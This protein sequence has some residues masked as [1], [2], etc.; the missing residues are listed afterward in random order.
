M[1]ARTSSQSLPIAGA[2]FALTLAAVAF[3]DSAPARAQFFFNLP[4]IGGFGGG[5][6]YYAPRRS[7]GGYHSGGSHYA[8]PAAP[9][10]NAPPPT[11]QDS[12]R[13][14]AAL[15]PSTQAQLEVLKSISYSQIL[16]EV[17][18]PEDEADVG[19]SASGEAARDYTSKIEDLI[20]RI[21][22]IQKREGS[23]KD[24]DIS[25]HGILESM[26]AAYKAA[27]LQRFETFLGENW[28]AERLREMIIERAS[29]DIA[30]LFDG[31]NRGAVSMGDLDKLIRKS[32][33]S[34]YA[35]LFETSELLA[36]N[37][38][39]SMF[40]QRL[41]Q[42]HGDLMNG[43]VRED[44]EQMLLRASNA[45]VSTFDPLLRR[46]PNGFAL[47]YRAQRI[48]FDCLSA[49][50]EAISQAE[51][52]ES[53]SP[54]EI[55]QRILDTDEKQ[56]SKWVSV[57]LMGDD[58]KVKTQDPMPLRVIWSATG[59]KEDASMYTRASDL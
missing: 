23:T 28:S 18:A 53:A 32:A 17:G 39:S 35:R 43:D 45:G 15:A 26:T 21:K 4:G 8:Q 2:I 3:G 52:N 30:G 57:Q 19:K 41:Y 27:N 38:S 5:P 34:V 22:T 59:P 6:H 56:C 7:Y 51:N 16:G 49:N 46:D 50:V 37:R 31:T 13:V 48:I 29:N 36:A 10:N 55:E 24:G 44:A 14:L 40:V 47:R 42:V 20:K 9:A 12:S 11:P 33:L 1:V 54:A 58:G 25:E